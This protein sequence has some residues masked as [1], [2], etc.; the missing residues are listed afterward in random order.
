MIIVNL[1]RILRSGFISFWR[2]GYV[3]ISSVMVLAVTLFVIGALMLGGAFLDSSLKS[4]QERVDISVTF[5]PEV[6]EDKILALKSS[7]ELL[8]EV[9]KVEYTSRDKE[10]ENFQIRHRDNALLIQSLNEV[11]NPFGARISIAATDPSQYES[12]ARFID[13]QNESGSAD[14]AIIDQISFKRDIINKLLGL[15]ETS[16]TVGLAVSILLI[17]L[18][19]LVTFTTISLAIYVSREEISVMRLVGANNSYIRGPFLIQGVIA[20]IMA[21][22]IAVTFLYPSVIWVRNTTAGVY[23]GINL[24]SYFVDNFAK[25]FLTLFLSGIMLGVIS[26]FLAVRKYLKV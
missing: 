19:I 8:P 25:V 21:S 23:G 16:R 10:L 12:I 7:L 13:S 14:G 6:S 24:V 2:N 15:I 20:G 18:S 17:C 1:K 26:S 11:G 9:S 22:F 4:V 5:K 3:A